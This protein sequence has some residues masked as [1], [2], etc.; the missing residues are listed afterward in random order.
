[1][2]TALKYEMFL[3]E[4][5]RSQRWGDPAHMADT[6][7]ATAAESSKYHL[8]MMKVGIAYAMLCYNDHYSEGKRLREPDDSNLFSDYID[9]V[10]DAASSEEL[11]KI[12]DRY[13]EYKRELDTLDNR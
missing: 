7:I 9:E 13:N 2:S 10:L 11:G 1:M 6:D 3:R 8:N 12:I 4:A 5:F